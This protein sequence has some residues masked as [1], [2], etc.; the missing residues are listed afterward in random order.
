VQLFNGKDLDGWSAIAPF[1]ILAKDKRDET[2]HATLADAVK[3]AQSGDTIEIRGDGPFE[4]EPI[5]PGEKALTIRAGAGCRPVLRLAPTHFKTGKALLTNYGPLTLEG[6]ELH[7]LEAGEAWRPGPVLMVYGPLRLANSKLVHLG[8]AH[9]VQSPVPSQIEIMN[10][11][12]VVWFGSCFQVNTA[13]A[14]NVVVDN[15]VF[16]ALPKGLLRSDGLLLETQNKQVTGTVK[17]RGNT[18]TAWY[19]PAFRYRKLSQWLA[20][21]KESEP[22]L[23][24]AARNVFAGPVV[25]NLNLMED[26]ELPADDVLKTVM[27]Q[28]NVWKEEGNLYH[29]DKH[30]F[31]A[32]AG[33]PSRAV[34]PTYQ[35]WRQLWGLD[36]PPC[37]EGKALFQGGALLANP[38]QDLLT[39]QPADF[40]LAKGSPSKGAGPG[41]K[42]LGADVDLVGPGEA[43]E[44]WKKTPEYQEWLS[45][46]CAQCCE[47]GAKLAVFPRKSWVF[48]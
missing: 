8:H 18:F 26:N 9:V 19:P 44:K 45:P 46:C 24:E 3:A 34:L 31:H 42:D 33:Q 37:L 39:I 35:D 2:R 15:C 22:I 17:L 7:R 41:G 14:S 23:H 13:I 10:T 27:K 25:G 29:F 11:L 43:Y 36:T 48:L 16:H 30:F 32:N 38:E 47:S 5:A 6:L 40:R 21:V 28:L 4:T 1:V 20:Q 12:M